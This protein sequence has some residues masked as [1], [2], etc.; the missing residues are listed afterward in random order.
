MTAQ[1]TAPRIGECELSL[2]GSGVGEC[3][4]IHLGNGDWVIVDSCFGGSGERQLIGL[5]WL[6]F[7]FTIRWRGRQKYKNEYNRNKSAEKR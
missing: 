7:G 2:F 5:G 3:I 1:A 4:V 6:R